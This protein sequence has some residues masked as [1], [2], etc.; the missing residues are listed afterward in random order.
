M[1]IIFFHRLWITTC[2]SP[3]WRRGGRGWVRRE[4]KRV[5]G[6]DWTKIWY[7]QIMWIYPPCRRTD[8]P[9]IHFIKKA[10]TNET[11]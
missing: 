9:L 2:E 11:R 5:P 1:S 3:E 8:K 10:K 7:F 6:H 4:G